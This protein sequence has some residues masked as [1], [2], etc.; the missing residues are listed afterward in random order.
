MSKTKR[1]ILDNYAI[2]LA[3]VKERVRAAHYD[4]LKRSTRSW[5]LFTGILGVL[6]PN[7][8][9]LAYTVLLW[10]NAWPRIYKRSFLVLSASP[11]AISST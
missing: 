3:E 1:L 5:S 9:L 6:P 2:L 11:G 7:A 8:R 4:A 10:S